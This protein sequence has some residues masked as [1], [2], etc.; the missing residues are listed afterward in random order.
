MRKLAYLVGCLT[1]L[2]CNANGSAEPSPAATGSTTAVAATATASAE[3]SARP[4]RVEPAKPKAYAHP[5]DDDIG[6]LPEGVGVAVGEKAP[7]F[8]LKQS[9]GMV[10]KLSDLLKKSEVLLTFYRGGW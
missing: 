9:D 8:E 1:L 5:T 3:G 4:M 7:D 6:T 2:A 10:V